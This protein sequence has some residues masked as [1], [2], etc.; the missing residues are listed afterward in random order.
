M[1]QDLFNDTE[2][3]ISSYVTLGVDNEVYA[4]D[5]RCVREILEHR[6]PVPLHHAPPCFVGVVDVRGTTVPVIDLSRK[7]GLPA[8]PVTVNTRILVLEVPLT[9]RTITVGLL[10]SRVFE[11]AELELGGLESTPDVGIAW[12]SEYI[13]AI[14]RLHGGFVTIF[15]MQKLFDSTELAVLPDVE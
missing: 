1:E 11:V 6:P 5:V 10:V 4:V 14:G 2:E 8:A 9:D 7:L 15:N 13:A 3:P 12:N